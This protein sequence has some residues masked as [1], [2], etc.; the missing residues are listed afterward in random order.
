MRRR[1]LRVRPSPF[2]PNTSVPCSSLPAS[3]A[4][5]LGLL[6]AGPAPADAAPAPGD[7]YNVLVFSKTA[8][9][10]HDS[11]PA[12]I[13]A[14]QQLGADNGFSVTA[15]EDAAAFTDAN[16]AQLRHRRLALDHRRR[17]RRRP[18][19][20]P[21]SAT[22]RPAAATSASTPPPTPST[23]GPGT[24]SSSARTSPRTRANQNATIKVEDPAHPSTADLPA[25][26]S[27]FDEW[28][29]FR[30]NPRGTVHVLASLDETSYAPGSGA[31][32]ADH[33]T[34]WC[35]DFDG[36]R[37]WYTG[38]GHTIESYSEPNFLSHL[39]GGIETT[40]GVV[41][42]DCSATQDRQLREGDAG[43]QH[44]EPDG[45][46][47]R[48]RRPGVLHRARRPGAGHLADHR[49]DHDGGDA[50]RVHRQ[51]GRPDRHPTRPGLRHQQLGLPLLRAGRRRAAQPTCPASP[52]PA[53]RSTWPPKR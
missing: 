27:R 40:A 11:I 47:H 17:A 23:T 31:M 45:A 48:A 13:A 8:G 39:L 15:T 10:R 33:P 1:R 42:A 29:N 7:P 49:P 46:R 5:V 12:G 35:Q 50:G 9:F 51:R 28:Y 24:A 44:A 21:S 36:G 16:L 41:D 19:R 30:T 34:A 18:S 2:C 14:I 52:S 25:E 53:T 43:Q 3:L 4:L 32:G 26:W 22:S 20:P 38:S 37:S 6:V